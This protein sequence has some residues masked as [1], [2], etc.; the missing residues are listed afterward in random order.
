MS[1]VVEYSKRKKELDYINGVIR[2]HI[3]K[4]SDE[5]W[6]VNVFYSITDFARFVGE[7]DFVDFV[8]VDVS[9]SIAIP[10]TEMI[11]Q[12]NKDAVI[13]VLADTSISPALYMKP[14]IMA[15]SLLL[16][17]INEKH[18]SET[19]KE[20]FNYIN[21][22]KETAENNF[23]VIKTKSQYE[24]I[25]YDKIVFLE[26]RDKKIFLNTTKKEYGFYETMEHVM[27]S[28]PDYFIRCHRG[29]VINSQ[30]I[31]KVMLSQSTVELAGGISVP[32][33]KSYKQGLKEFKKQ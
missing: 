26:A 29:F 18:V 33:S 3:A 21:S 27:E 9:E 10:M 11:R 25:P 17:P 2:S 14:S 24:H 28:L 22:S 32:I 8:C 20:L 12:N 16:F 4:L 19:I 5:D 1:T 31:E 15:A 13:L 30:K 7:C 6:N 23:F